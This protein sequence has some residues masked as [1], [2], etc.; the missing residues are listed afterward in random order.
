MTDFELT[1]LFSQKKLEMSGSS[2]LMKR[3]SRELR[4]ME[5]GFC[6]GLMIIFDKELKRPM[7]KLYT[8]CMHLYDANQMKVYDWKDQ[9]TLGAVRVLSHS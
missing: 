4:Q 1:R 9:P 2:G 3:T 8:Y 6:S 7:W 5:K